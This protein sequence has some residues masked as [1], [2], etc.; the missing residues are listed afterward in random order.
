MSMNKNYQNDKLGYVKPNLDT[1]IKSVD[2]N[3]KLIE[4]LKIQLEEIKNKI[5]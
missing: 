5:K 1:L 2:V 3:S 4:E